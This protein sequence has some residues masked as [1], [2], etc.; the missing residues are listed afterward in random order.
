MKPELTMEFRM[1][2][3]KSVTV[4]VFLVL[5]AAIPSPAQ[6]RYLNPDLPPDERARDLVGQ[7][8]LDEKISQMQNMAAAIP[9]LGVPAY[10]WWSEA[11][12]GVAFAGFA[13][14]FPQAIGAGATWNPELLHREAVVIST[15]ARAKYR[16]FLRKGS[17]EGREGLDF[18]SPNINIFRDP[19]WGRGQE[20]YG[21]DPFLTGRMGVAFIRGMQGED[22][23]YLKTI[24]TPKHYAVHSGPESDRHHFDARPPVRDL[25]E[26]YLPAFEA[27]I[28]EA[29]AWSIMG[30]YNRVNGDPA[31][32]SNLLL[33]GL[34]REKWGFKGYVVSDCGAIGD[35]H[36][37]HKV[38]KNAA[39]SSARAVKAGCDLSCG[40]EYDSLRQAVAWKLI[41]EEEISTSTIRLMEARF[42]LGMFDPPGRNPFDSIPE[43]AND[44]PEHGALAREVARESIVLL[45]NER[46][47][48]P[49]NKPKS[50]AVIGPFAD[51]VTVL[52]GNYNGTPS[53]PVTILEGIKRRAGKEC[54]I[55]FARG[56]DIAT[57]MP[58][59]FPV[60]AR[61][62]SVQDS[63]KMQPGLHVEFFA[64]VGLSGTPC[65]VR[66]DTAVTFD[67]VRESPGAGIPADRYS[68][69][70]TGLLTTDFSG[71]RNI[72][73]EVDDG[74]RLYIDDSLVVDLWTRGGRRPATAEYSFKA[75]RPYRIRL[76][77]FEGGGEA[78]ITLGWSDES[79][80][81]EQEA[82]AAAD[83][84]EVIVAVMGLCPY[85]EG[86]EMNISIDGFKG[87]DRTK[88]EIPSP[89][90]MLL[91][92]LVA[93]G[94]PVVLV[95]T[96]GSALS[97]PWEKEHVPA[98]LEAWYPGQEGGNAVADVLFGDYNPAGRLPVTFY[99]SVDDLPSFDN[100]AM[101]G[102]TY[103]YFHSPSLY[104]FGYGLS[105]TSFDYRKA[106]VVSE[107]V[108]A[109][110]TI[111]LDVTVENTG[112]RDGDE[113]VQIYAHAQ[114][115][116]ADDAI[117]S[118]V[119]FKRIHIPSG[120]LQT[121]RIAIPVHE[122][123]TYDPN[124]HDYVVR[125]GI[126]NLEIGSSSADITLH[127]TISVNSM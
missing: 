51:D 115:S 65:A 17:I 25:Y 54:T 24:A 29:G 11:L 126:Y 87:G 93:T 39:E 58:R 32:A 71:S 15:E 62:L 123:R 106:D 117:K 66:R 1:H 37:N 79:H 118:L 41:T 116:L 124:R 14:V 46:G 86:E 69:R 90:E 50:I 64:N 111:Y 122:L 108:M 75:G 112:H 34:L 5:F 4:F 57:G 114:Q 99:R 43:S 96:S 2:A 55:S 120:T 16:G 83:K 98:I 77:Y 94:K 102:R 67:W 104:P 78:S 9:R 33:G 36:A 20:T 73:V 13:T 110:D 31:C 21:E 49:L 22:S 68:A 35:I 8:T 84:S 48:L 89:Q 80:K 91:K 76:E 7:M 3:F 6:R 52:V 109:K 26:T 63:G 10:D 82:L 74:A 107:R 72:G 18:W 47:A 121:A 105:F 59:L 45:K 27:S 28:V 44:T 19:R 53:H 60:E 125:P 70:W 42:R 56:C 103:R 113:V 119:G 100:Y 61:Y 12:H 23:R 88:L 38:A 30:A 92:K 101:A 127:R 97:I 85:L 81:Q 95:L 40:G